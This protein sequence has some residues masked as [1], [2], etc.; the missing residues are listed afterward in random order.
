MATVPKS[1]T[2]LQTRKIFFSVVNWSSFCNRVNLWVREK[3]EDT[4]GASAHVNV[5]AAVEGCPVNR[6]R[7]SDGP[8]LQ[9]VGVR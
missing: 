8:R 5:A 2:A 7:P 6:G 4:T 3:P 1:L 9:G